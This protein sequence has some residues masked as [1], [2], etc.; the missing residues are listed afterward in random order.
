MPKPIV[1]LISILSLTSLSLKSQTVGLEMKSGVDQIEIPFEYKNNFILIDIIFNNTLPLKFIFDTGAEYTIINKREITDLLGVSYEKEFRLLGSDMTTELIAYLCRGVNIDLNELH[2]SKQ[3]I[4]VL[5]EDYFRI[6]EFT[7]ID[8]HGILGANFFKRYII[9]IDYR[10]RVIQFIKPEIF[11]SPN[12][13]YHE[14]PARF[15]KNKPYVL[16]QTQI[17]ADTIL[18]LSMLIDSG[19]SLALLIHTNSNRQI[20]LPKTT[21]EGQLG[22]GLG[23]FLTGFLGRTHLLELNNKLA[24]QNVITSFQKIT[25]LNDT[26]HMNGRNG[27]IGNLLLSR[28]TVMIDY[29][30]EKVYLKPRKKYNRGFKYD[31]SGLGIIA[32][33]SDFN[34]FIVTNVVKGS[35]ADLAGV[36]KG[37]QILR[38][39]LL[40]SSFYSLSHLT[41]ILQ[42]RD[43]KKIRMKIRRNGVKKKVIFRLKSLI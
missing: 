27:V 39:N 26:T 36:Q 21:I 4:L 38:L 34:E 10:K 12:K 41:S 22:M 35:P 19:A 30:R 28:F 16:C 8:V 24:F 9:K 40:S 32:S 5:A 3:D 2:G 17:I 37:D 6:E 33:G 42:G 43:G 18:P 14:V 23:G 25:E 29:P 13:D 20:N 31:K 11:N 7:G 15:T 1:Y